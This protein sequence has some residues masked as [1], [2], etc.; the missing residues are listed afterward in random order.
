VLLN[1]FAGLPM[2]HAVRVIVLVGIF[3]LQ[4]ETRAGRALAAEQPTTH[5]G[6]GNG[7]IRVEIYLAADRAKDLDAI[8][9][10]FATLGIHKVQPQIFRAGRPPWNIAIGHGIPAEVA[11]MAMALAVTYNQGITYL[12]S[13]TRLMDHYIGIGTSLFDELFQIPISPENLKRLQDPALDTAA[14]HALYQE[15]APLAFR[16]SWDPLVRSK[17]GV[18]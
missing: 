18:P 14:F 10:Q 13:E 3:L 17:A 16:P 9:A 5:P 12:V 11:R 8:R 1:V 15:L 7:K 6:E 4:M 2:R